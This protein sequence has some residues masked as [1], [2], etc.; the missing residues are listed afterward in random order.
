MNV[1]GCANP[2]NNKTTSELQARPDWR[3]N[4]GLD[5]LQV[6]AVGGPSRFWFSRHEDRAEF[7]RLFEALGATCTIV[8]MKRY[9][10]TFIGRK[11][12]AIGIEYAVTRTIEAPDQETAWMRV[13]ETHEHIHRIS[14]REITGEE[15]E[16]SK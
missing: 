11:N 10:C 7:A 8:P 15:L 12:G 4:L 13:Y 14:A 5:L 9:Q 16:A 3:F 2:R 1:P 6:G